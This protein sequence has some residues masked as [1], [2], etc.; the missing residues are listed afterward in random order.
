MVPVSLSNREEKLMGLRTELGQV[1]LEL[2]T[3]ATEIKKELVL[4]VTVEN[5]IGYRAWPWK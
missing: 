1:L 3:R 4:D 5:G 2:G